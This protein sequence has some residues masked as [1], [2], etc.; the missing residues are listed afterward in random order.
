MADYE[1]TKAFVDGNIAY[2]SDVEAEFNA[3]RTN[4]NER[5]HK[6]GSVDFAAEQT[7]KMAAPSFVLEE[8]SGEK[9][10]LYLTDNI[11]YVQVYVGAAWVTVEQISS[12]EDRLIADTPTITLESKA[13]GQEIRY[14]LYE[15]SKVLKLQYS[16]SSPDAWVDVLEHNVADAEVTITGDLEV[17]GSAEIAGD[18]VVT[19]DLA[20]TGDLNATLGPASV[21]YSSLKW[22]LVA[23]QTVPVSATPTFTSYYFDIPAGAPSGF[24]FAKFTISGMLTS[25]F[26]RAHVTEIGRA[27]TAGGVPKISVMVFTEKSGAGAPIC[28]LRVY[29][30]SE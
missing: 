2:G 7:I 6:D 30:L 24:L 29:A 5:I 27:V 18:A 3:M 12:T 17:T 13:T 1:R 26:V 4:L 19:G 20:V 11:L 15:D 14:R 25:T 23:T 8:N 21:V 10:R 28:E 22:I 9:W 16:V